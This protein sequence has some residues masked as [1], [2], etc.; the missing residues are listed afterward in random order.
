[1]SCPDGSARRHHPEAEPQDR[2]F[3]PI[4]GPQGCVWMPSH[5]AV[6]HWDRNPTS[7]TRLMSPEDSVRHMAVDRRR[8]GLR[9]DDSE[10]SES[11]MRLL[12]E[13]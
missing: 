9:R 13:G 3:A 6:C 10:H 8:P 11:H 7:R 5:V 4:L 1:M 2:V 12:T